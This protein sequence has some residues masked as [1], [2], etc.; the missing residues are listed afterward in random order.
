MAVY[1]TI[2]ICE[3]QHYVAKAPTTRTKA[4]DLRHTQCAKEG[5]LWRG[6]AARMAPTACFPWKFYRPFPRTCP[7]YLMP[8]VHPVSRLASVFPIDP[9]HQRNYHP[10]SFVVRLPSLQ[11][12]SLHVHSQSFWWLFLVYLHGLLLAM[13]CRPFSP[14]N[15][16][17]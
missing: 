17:N 16:V 10:T 4:D 12:L 3:M 9:F 2:Y 5:G 8:S 1:K 7:C 6:G 15:I 13:Q 14:D 11:S